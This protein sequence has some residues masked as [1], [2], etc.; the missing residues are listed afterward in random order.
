MLNWEKILEET[1]GKAWILRWGVHSLRNR[2]SL[3]VQDE[4]QLALGLNVNDSLVYRMPISLQ[5]TYTNDDSLL[6]VVVG[7]TLQ[8]NL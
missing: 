5:V 1:P 8:D 2:S 7:C 4:S 3:V 6:R